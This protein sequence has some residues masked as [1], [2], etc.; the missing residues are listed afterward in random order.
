VP[1][2][3]EEPHPRALGA[4]C[5]PARDVVEGVDD[6]AVRRGVWRAEE[7]DDREQR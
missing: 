2:L 5:R 1:R 4:G 3:R 7:Q 6:D